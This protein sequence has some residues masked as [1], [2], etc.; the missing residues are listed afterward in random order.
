MPD[1]CSVTQK[2]PCIPDAFKNDA[3]FSNVVIAGKKF[4]APG[5]VGDNWGPR[6]GLAW[7]ITPRTILRTG[8]GLYWDAI[9]ARSQYAQNDL[10]MAVW[11]DATAYAARSTP[12]RISRMAQRQ[13]SLPSN[14]KVFQIRCRQRIRG[15]PPTHSRTIR[16]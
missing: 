3:H 2:A 5:P 12:S 1:V 14:R 13:I 16:N 15:R 6:V 11:P 8:Y 7:S 10:E 4:F 9:T